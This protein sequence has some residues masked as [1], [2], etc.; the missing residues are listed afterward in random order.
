MGELRFAKD[1][2]QEDSTASYLNR[3]SNRR[4][5]MTPSQKVDSQIAVMANKLFVIP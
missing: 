2:M 1:S 3:R 5:G 4:A